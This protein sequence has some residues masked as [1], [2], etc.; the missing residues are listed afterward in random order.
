MDG[1]TP[2]VML[3]RIQN[4]PRQQ[5]DH[6]LEQLNAV[7]EQHEDHL[8]GLRT[9]LF[10]YIESEKLWHYHPGDDVY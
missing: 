10:E 5:Q 4:Q 1:P 9:E 3:R 8:L 6:M 2:E 7:M